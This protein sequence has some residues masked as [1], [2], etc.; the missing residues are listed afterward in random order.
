MGKEYDLTRDALT[1]IVD[2][3]YKNKIY[4]TDAMNACLCPAWREKT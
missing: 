4:D 1:Q 3:A 2:L